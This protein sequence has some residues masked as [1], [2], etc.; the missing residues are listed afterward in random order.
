VIGAGKEA[1]AVRY[2][3]GTAD[4]ASLP[5]RDFGRRVGLTDGM[6]RISITVA[7]FDAVTAA[8]PLG[9]LV[10]N[11]TPTEAA[12]LIW[13]GCRRRRARSD[14]PAPG[15]QRLDHTGSNF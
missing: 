9:K 8:L 11:A 6:I 14:E 5:E 12:S 10:S 15:L 1:E 13:I 4:H 7:A 3:S 2:T